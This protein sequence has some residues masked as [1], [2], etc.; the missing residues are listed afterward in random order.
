M[1]L[2]SYRYFLMLICVAKMDFSDQ[3]RMEVEAV[4]VR[5]DEKLISSKAYL[6][7]N[8]FIEDLIRP[9]VNVE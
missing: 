1:I 5:C 7:D 6:S 8:M 2:T 9:L 4:D 3:Y